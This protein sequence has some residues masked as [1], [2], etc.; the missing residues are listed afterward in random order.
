MNQR[1]SASDAPQAWRGG[2]EFQV[3]GGSTED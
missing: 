1:N 2:V 3:I